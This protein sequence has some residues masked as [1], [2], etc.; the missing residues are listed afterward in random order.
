MRQTGRMS[1]LAVFR[2]ENGN[3]TARA[4]EIQSLASPV[5]G[6][7]DI[8]IDAIRRRILVLYNGDRLALDR[9]LHILRGLGLEAGLFSIPCGRYSRG[10]GLSTS[11]PA[12]DCSAQAA[13]RRRT[14]SRMS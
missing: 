9:I 1:V 11:G 8:R 6:V 3:C 12:K 13:H 14:S 7:G 4:D 5:P 10:R 2:V